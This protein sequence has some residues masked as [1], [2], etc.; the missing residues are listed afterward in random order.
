MDFLRQL[1]RRI[2]ARRL[3]LGHTRKVVADGA[4]ISVTQLVL[5]ESGQGHPPAATLHRIAMTLGTSSSEL[6]G[7]ML[8]DN[9]EQIDELVQLYTHPVVGAVVRHMQSMSKEDRK[10]LQVVAT[11]FANRANAA[12]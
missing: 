1:G 6:L 5:Y 3:H 4:E 12:G 9:G 11:A 10:S 8:V 7:E 2:R